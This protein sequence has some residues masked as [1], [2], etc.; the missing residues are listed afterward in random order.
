ME[1]LWMLEA[2][3]EETRAVEEEAMLVLE[4]QWM[5]EEEV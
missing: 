2:I 4:D 5:Q 1:D 3:L